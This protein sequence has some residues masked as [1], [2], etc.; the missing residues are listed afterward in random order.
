MVGLACIPDDPSRLCLINTFELNMRQ[1]WQPTAV[2]GNCAFSRR[3]S[4]TDW[5]SQG[6]KKAG[7]T[8]FQTFPGRT[9]ILSQRVFVRHSLIKTKTDSSFHGFLRY[10][11]VWQ[12]C[13]T[14][15][16]RR[17]LS[18]ANSAMQSGCIEHHNFYCVPYPV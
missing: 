15:F 16:L 12:A 17:Y 11:L 8:G 6:E 13:G 2:P 10:Q 9:A 18:Q 1:H 7:S 4:P 3:L 5:L 14:C